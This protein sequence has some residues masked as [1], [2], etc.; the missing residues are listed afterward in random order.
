MSDE[1]KLTR[2]EITKIHDMGGRRAPRLGYIGLGFRGEK[3]GKR[4]IDEAGHF[5]FAEQSLQDFPEIGD[6]YVDRKTGALEP[7]R[8]HVMFTTGER[9]DIFPYAYELTGGDGRCKCRGNG[10]AAVR[11][12]CAECKKMICRHYEAER[13]EAEVACPCELLDQKRC[14]PTGRLTF[15]LY[16]ATWA[17]VWTV[18]THS[19]NSIKDILAGLDQIGTAAGRLAYVPLELRLVRARLRHDGRLTWKHILKIGIDR[20]VAYVRGCLEDMKPP[21][22]AFDPPDADEDKSEK[23]EARGEKPENNAQGRDRPP[24]QGGAASAT[25]GAAPSSSRDE[26]TA[27]DDAPRGDDGP[28]FDDDPP[29]DGPTEKQ[30]AGSERREANATLRPCSAKPAAQG[31]EESSAPLRSARETPACLRADT[32]RQATGAQLHAIETLM[33]R[34]GYAEDETK[35]QTFLAALGVKS[36][37]ALTEAG[38]RKAIGMLQEERKTA[39][40]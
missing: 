3:D 27:V 22:A 11:S 17:G 32:H 28:L 6:L 14:R 31:E 9:R 36:I 25:R 2:A 24:A 16:R 35:R 37:D 15:M 19:W 13:M 39:G 29:W 5:V 34:S 26:G 12:L 38:A 20:D 18:G 7:K 23:P 1:A 4:S 8:L 30:Q 33:T 10:Q 40:A 21:I